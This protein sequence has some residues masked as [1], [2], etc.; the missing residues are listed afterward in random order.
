MEKSIDEIIEKYKRGTSKKNLAQEYKMA[1]RTIS[2]I[3]KENNIPTIA[4]SN[5]G[6]W[7]YPGQIIELYRNNISST[8]IG[9]IFNVSDRTIINILRYHGVEIKKSGQKTFRDSNYFKEIKTEEQAYALGLLRSDGCILENG[10]ISFVQ[11]A[12]RK[13][14]VEILS[15]IFNVPLK[16]YLARDEYY[17]SL[18]QLSWKEDLAKHGIIPRKSLESPGIK[19]ELIPKDLQRHYLR[20]L[21]DGDGLCYF[22]QGS[23]VLGFCS[24][25][26]QDVEEFF[27]WFE[28]EEK[29]KIY[30][31]TVYFGS[32]SNFKWVNCFY[33]KIYHDATLYGTLKRKRI[34]ERLNK[35]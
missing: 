15:R 27:N 16:H 4:S 3:L 24:S 23:L 18:R 10:T 5:R 20:G 12:D 8:E 19:L 7:F 13:E 2:R 9:K 35:L 11:G 1:E 14:L 30:F 6:L 21:F 22:N 29:F 32:K 25:F 34:E 17:L 33:D 26:K 31:G 28:E